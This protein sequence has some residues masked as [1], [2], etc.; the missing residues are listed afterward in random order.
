MQD[1]AGSQPRMRLPSCKKLNI[2]VLRMLLKLAEQWLEEMA[3]QSRTAFN[4]NAA[5]KLERSNKKAQRR[6]RVR[7]LWSNWCEEMALTSS[8][9]FR[10]MASRSKEN[11]KQDTTTNTPNSKQSE[12]SRKESASF[13]KGHLASV[14]IRLERL[15]VQVERI[16]EYIKDPFIPAK[17]SYLSRESSRVYQAE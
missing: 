17:S 15:E 5:K 1:K 11:Q 9:M 8:S 4:A 16:K 13:S 10:A 2:H 14:E 7:K 12:K 3:R 6:A